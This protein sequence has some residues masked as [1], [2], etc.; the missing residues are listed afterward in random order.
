MPR[1]VKK[2]WVK[3]MVLGLVGK[4]LAKEFEKASRDVEGV[5]QKV[6]FRLIESCKETAFGRDHSFEKIQTH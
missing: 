5:Q 2:Q 6:L 3:K 4:P 1:K